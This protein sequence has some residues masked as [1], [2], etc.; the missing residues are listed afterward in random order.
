MAFLLYGTASVI[1]LVAIIKELILVGEM[2]RLK[3]ENLVASFSFKFDSDTFG[4]DGLANTIVVDVEV[5][6]GAEDDAEIESIFIYDETANR[7]LA[8][9]QFSVKEQAYIEKKAYEIA[10]ENA[11]EVYYDALMMRA[12]DAWDES[13]GH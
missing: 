4:T 11:H 13:R 6:A 8:L 3:K 9:E 2:A 10:Q 7:E 1:L 5:Y 12:E